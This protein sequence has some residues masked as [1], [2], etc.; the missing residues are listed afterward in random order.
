LPANAQ[1]Y[2]RRIEQLIGGRIEFV[3]VGP[4]RRQTIIMN[5]SS[6]VRELAGT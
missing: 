3:S 5:R 4:D 1:K 6:E 2:V